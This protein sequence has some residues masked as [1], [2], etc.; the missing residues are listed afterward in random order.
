[1]VLKYGLVLIYIYRVLQVVKEKLIEESF[2]DF[3][4][5]IEVYEQKIY[6]FVKFDMNYILG[7]DK[8][9]LD[10][11]IIKYKDI[12]FYD[13]LD[14]LYDLVWKEVRVCIKDNF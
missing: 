14:L 9:C 6:V 10:V 13:L 12:D 7:L 2:N 1:M 4:V 11:V 3:F 5:G 8:C